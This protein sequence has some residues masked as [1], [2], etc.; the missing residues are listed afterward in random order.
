MGCQEID[1]ER[2]EEIMTSKPRELHE[3]PDTTMVNLGLLPVD[4]AQMM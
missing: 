3:L 2:K 1:K 4:S